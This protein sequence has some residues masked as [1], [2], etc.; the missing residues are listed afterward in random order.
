M[1]RTDEQ[2]RDD[3]KE[4]LGEMIS[5]WG[6]DDEAIEGGTNLVADLGLSSVDLI[7]LMASV[8]MRF[9]RK[10]PYDEIIMKDGQYAN[11]I[12]VDELVAFVSR[13]IDQPARG[14]FGGRSFR[15]AGP[16]DR[17][18]HA[19]ELRDRSGQLDRRGL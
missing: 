19:R 10:L 2:I 17:R 8:E 3:I 6:L 9:H 15:R 11:D 12:S 7:H 16:S 5:T 18:M 13:N 14:P 4:I 1:S